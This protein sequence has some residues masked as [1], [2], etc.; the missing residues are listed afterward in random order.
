VEQQRGL[1]AELR[2]PSGKLPYLVRL[3]AAPSHAP[4]PRAGPIT[5]FV[6]SRVGANRSQAEAVSKALGLPEGGALLI[7]GPP[8]TGKSTTAAEI[9]A[10]LVRGD[11][12]ARVLVCSHS[13]H[14]TDNIL[15]KTAATLPD[16]SRQLARI[17]VPDRV[18]Q[19]AQPYYAEPWT[20]LQDRSV[21]FTTVDSMVL[22][23]TVGARLYDYVILDEANRAG[24][25][26]SLL[27]LARGTR[28]ILVGDP[29]QLQPV[30]SE[31]QREPAVPG[32]AAL[33]SNNSLFVW[34]QGH[35]FPAEA[36][37]FLAE[38]NR[39]HVRI[40]ELVSRVFYGGRVVAGPSAPRAGTGMHRFPSPVT[41]VDT[42]TL[43]HSAERRVEGGSVF[44]AAEAQLV[45]S[46]TRV[47]SEEAPSGLSIGVISAY[48]EQTRLLQRLLQGSGIPIERHLEVDT[49]DAFEGRE[50]D[51]IILSLVR[52]NRIGDIGFLRFQQ[53]LNVAIS[54][55]RRSLIIVGHTPTL[56][57]GPFPEL[58]AA[59]AELGSVVPA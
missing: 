43:A 25:L 41:W 53:R 21:V 58:L 6:D 50:K 48:A 55:A 52:T 5:S 8:G 44:N 39:M 40:G 59:V 9:V 22:Q 31:A 10:Q 15:L 23:D 47:V 7:Q 35:G 45:A 34:L 46:L 29:M 54:R 14:G 28:M 51:V 20:D 11:T 16:A 33:S 26:D 37:A 32:S 42:R 57:E 17:G 2:D 3:V 38:Q 49:V 19:S 27:A 1:L 18:A 36:S 56:R 12:F 13:N 24:I 30:A 4:I